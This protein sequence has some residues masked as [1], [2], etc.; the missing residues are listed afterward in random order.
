MRRVLALRWRLRAR[1]AL[2]AAKARARLGGAHLEVVA[3]PSVRLE[4]GTRISVDRGTTGRIELGPGAWLHEGVR[5]QLR[6]GTVRLGAG[7][8]VRRGAVLN[9]AGELV[10]DGDNVIS[11]YSVVHCAERVHLARF[12]SLSEFCTVVDSRHFHT[13]EATGYYDNVESAPVEIGANVWLAAKA[14]V[15]MGV[16]IGEHAVVAAHAVV[17]KDVPARALVGG[18]PARVIEQ[19]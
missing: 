8:S 14:S 16:T 2:G 17:H 7:S 19:R 6:G 3:H 12:A 13:D 11:Y 4:R 10:L 18:V 15:L 9:V 1:L 5:I